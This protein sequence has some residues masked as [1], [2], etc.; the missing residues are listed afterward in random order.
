MNL[1]TWN[2]IVHNSRI[3]LTPGTKIGSHQISALIG[4]GGMGEVYRATDTAL[5]RQV[6]IKLIKQGFG[7]KEFI[8]HFRQDERILAALN[9]PNIARLY[10]GGSGCALNQSARR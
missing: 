2:S 6:A 7:T 4:V 9:H 3:A 1:G 10:G 5:G 8:R